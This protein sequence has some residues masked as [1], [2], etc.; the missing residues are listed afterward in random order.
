MRLKSGVAFALVVAF[1]LAQVAW[2][3]YFQIREAEIF[4]QAA[5]ALVSGDRDAVE[6]ALGID[7]DGNVDDRFRRRRL[8]FAAE[9]A[10]LG[11]CALAGVVFFYATL[12]RERRMW[13]ERDRFL[14]GAAHEFRTPITTIRL[15]LD[16][17]LDDRVSESRR[18]DYANAM[19]KEVDRLERGLT[20]LLAA[21]GL[22]G[23]ATS[24]SLEHGSIGHDVREVLDEFA[25]RYAAAG[26]EFSEQ[27]LD[28]VVVARDPFAVRIAVH[29]LLDNALRYN[30][31]GG[32][33]SF[34]LRT[35]GPD[36][37]M[38]I[39][40]TGI[41]IEEQEQDRVFEPFFRGSS[42]EH[43]GG[44]GLGLHLVREFVRRHGGTVR[45][46]SAGRGRGSQFV[47]RLPLAKQNG[48]AR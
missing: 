29:N 34:E 17:I 14:T 15:G 46:A 8:M 28:D 4:E 21:A 12:L 30:E 13:R 19:A 32:R 24:V 23:S 6:A 27:V 9:G 43:I 20:N 42:A 11:L 39:E 26:I 2:W 37:E 3:I 40:D 47:V 38:I 44:T 45:V 41:G 35:N 36:A 33:V 10:F 31:S 5:R 22:R 16:T 1:C 18:L 25:P 48:V 7:A